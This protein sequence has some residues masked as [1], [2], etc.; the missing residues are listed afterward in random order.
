[1]SE[2]ALSDLKVLEFGNLVSA[3]Y[4]GKLM[5]DLGAEVIKIEE[6]GLGDEA[7]SREPFA[8]DMP[9]IE[10][11]GLFA[12]LN[13]NK[14]SITLNPITTF[15]KAIFKELV[16]GADILVEN[17]PPRL[18][19]ELGLTY[20]VL[21]KI[22]PQLIMTSITPFGQTGPHRDY[23]AHELNTYN[24]GGYGIISTACIEE[25][26]M[27]PIKGGGSQSEFGAGQAAAVAAMCAFHARDQISAGQHIDLSIQELMAGQYES[28][29][30]HWTFDEN[31]MGGI[32]DPVI[33]PILPL[34]CKD[35]WIFLMCVEDYQYDRFV[36]LMGNPEWTE[37]ELFKDRFSRAEYLDALIPL[38]TEWTM[39]YTKDEVFKMCQAARVPVGPCYNSE[40]ILNSEQLAARNYF[41]E[42]DHPVIGRVKYPGAP[43]RLSLTPW[44]IE[45][46]APLLGE[47]NEEIFCERLG[48][49]KQDLVK[50]KQSGVI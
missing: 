10:M 33:Q 23:K 45:R 28:A 22:N 46:R 8:K 1:M 35:G 24:A 25:P 39:Q 6:P 26:V 4:C 14:L 49:T 11:S 31:E 16:N 40:E 34:E 9:G 5:A 32:S 29:I 36:E 41:V 27:P 42:I 18:M 44:R 38:L 15:G 2:G 47:H 20:E 17:Q 19:D 48:Y 30:E 13:T 37:N 50:L 3:P 21:E 43:Y 12:Y 7:R